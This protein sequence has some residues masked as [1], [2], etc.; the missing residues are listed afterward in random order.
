VA[1]ALLLVA[2]VAWG[3]TPQPRDRYREPVDYGPYRVEMQRVIE[4][5]RFDL[6]WR[7]GPG[8]RRSARFRLS[9]VHTPGI[10]VERDCEREKGHEAK[11]FVED[12]VRKKSLKVRDVRRG[13]D[14]RTWVGRLE[15]EGQ[16]L[17]QALLEAGLAVPYNDS[18]RN[19][20]RRR[21]V[22]VGQQDDPFEIFRE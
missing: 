4:G 3:Q 10:H 12:F 8:S 6:R 22:C 7:E 2:A 14:R 21:W 19:P 18:A 17:S 13:R 1:A 5:F 9:D 20:E 15:A 11:T 16:D